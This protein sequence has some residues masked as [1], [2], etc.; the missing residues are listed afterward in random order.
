MIQMILLILILLLP[1]STEAAYKIYLKDGSVISGVEYYK[2]KGSDVD[3][4][5]E[6]GSMLVSEEDI[7]KIEGKESAESYISPEDAQVTKDDMSVTAPQEPASDIPDKIA[8]LKALKSDVDALNE[9]IRSVNIEEAQLVTTINEKRNEKPVWNKY[10]MMQMEN[11]LKPLSDELHAVQQKKIE[12][13]E[14][15]GALETE[16][17]ELKK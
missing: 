6:N 13:L 10:Q 12:L 11:E 5:F 9:Q 2:K 4:F 1:V 15:K 14:K 17:S 3:L 7:L 16:I 8:R